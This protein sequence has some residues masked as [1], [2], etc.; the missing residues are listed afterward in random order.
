MPR[1]RGR[2]ARAER[3]RLEPSGA[4]PQVLRLFVAVELPPDIKR[5]LAATIEMLRDAARSDALRWVRIDGIHV[6]LEFLGD[7]E[8]A[9]VDAIG[10][11]LGAGVRHCVPFDITPAG[12]GSFGG[13]GHM[14]VVWIG[15][16]GDSGALADLADSVAASLEPLGLRREERAF[17]AHLTLAR[18]RDDAPAAE[19][20]RLHD[21]VT[22]FN[23][24][25]FPWFRVDRVSLMQSTLAPG[26]A[27]YRALATFPLDGVTPE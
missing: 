11:A 2:G 9:R 17:N 8:A 7:V 22:R 18:V 4:E 25:E 14:R 21:L 23:A 19:R 12:I 20:A 24:P 5:V 26:G 16:G 10:A 6:T 15:V 1:L 13:R 3:P 27:T